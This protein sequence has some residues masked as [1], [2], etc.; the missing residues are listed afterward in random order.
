MHIRLHRS[1]TGAAL[2]MTVV[3][4]V[5]FV[6]MT[7]AMVTLSISQK[8]EREESIQHAQRRLLAEAGISDATA[9]FRAGGTGIVG[10]SDAPM[11]LGAGEYFVTMTQNDDGTRFLDSRGTVGSGARTLRATVRPRIN[12]VWS[13]AMFAGNSG[14][15][16][17]YDLELEGRDVDADTVIGDLYSGG[18]VIMS[19]D[20][21][22][23]ETIRALGTISGATGEE[24][25]TQPLPDLD[26]ANYPVNNDVN[27]S[28][29]FDSGSA[30][31]ESDPLGGSAWT[32]PDTEPAHIFRKNPSDRTSKT[33]LTA[34]DDYFLEDPYEVVNSGISPSS[35]NATSVSLSYLDE[36]KGSQDGNDLIYYI[37]G[38][39]WVDN[40]K[41]R[42]VI[43]KHQTRD[44]RVTF[45]AKG[46]IYINDNLLIRNDNNDGIA[47]I[48]LSDPDV[49]DSG[50]VYL[51]DGGS[52]P[53]ALVEAFIYAQNDIYDTNYKQTGGG[54]NAVTETAINGVLAAGG[55]I[56]SARTARGQHLPRTVTHDSRI[57]DGS[58]EIPGLPENEGSR[59]RDRLRLTCTTR[60]APV[61][62]PWR[63]SRFSRGR[64]GPRRPTARR[65]IRTRWL[66]PSCI[67]WTRRLPSR[68]RITSGSASAW[69]SSR[70]RV[71]RDFSTPSTA[72][73]ATPAVR[74]N[75][76]CSIERSSRWDPRT[77]VLCSRRAPGRRPSSRI[78]RDSWC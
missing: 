3:V 77:C 5:V 30:T 61:S 72:S 60:C 47:F 48:A 64:R 59:A 18:D 69:R 52:Q 23:D 51:G 2:Y 55:Q 63:S 22:V 38:N 56:H 53:V 11:V 29:V 34:K 9:L 37:D 17:S 6:A 7:T 74:S 68:R 27:V 26:G 46:N 21:T 42:N 66:R 8:E 70:S 76:R 25:V 50:N 49:P 4:L 65:S 35:D 71:A 16:M 10:S 75:A 12:G 13:H 62:S 58:L 73:A 40:S 45:V 31:Y 44:V 67:C 33:D 54:K 78:A 41:L 39:L 15:D 14:A 36:N 1:D 32:L 57:I 24:G 28:D 43:I 20:A 19:G